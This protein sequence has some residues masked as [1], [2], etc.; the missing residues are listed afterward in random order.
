MKQTIFKLMI[1]SCGV[2]SGY[3]L[4]QKVSHI[5]GVFLQNIEALAGYEHYEYF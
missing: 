1:A 3:C 5:S 4:S 2:I